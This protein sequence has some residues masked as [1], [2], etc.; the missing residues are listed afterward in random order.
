MLLAKS[1][2]NAITIHTNKVGSPCRIHACSVEP[3]LQYVQYC[4]TLWNP[5]LKRDIEAVE[6]LQQHNGSAV[7]KISILIERMAMPSATHVGTHWR[8]DTKSKFADSS[9]YKPSRKGKEFM[10]W[11][12]IQ[13]NFTSLPQNILQPLH[14]LNYHCKDSHVIVVTK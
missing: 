5:Y 1:F 13:V 11:K 10:Q 6:K 3:Y 4:C 7:A 12:L 9:C 2:E 8:L 14:L